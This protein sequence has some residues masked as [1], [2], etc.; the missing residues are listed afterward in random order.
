[1]VLT[2]QLNYTNYLQSFPDAKEITW[3]S[4]FSILIYSNSNLI[5]PTKY[6]SETRT[7]LEH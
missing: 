1:M 2:K 4:G 6:I 3:A 5:M 7:S